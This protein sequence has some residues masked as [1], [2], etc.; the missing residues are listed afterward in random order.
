MTRTSAG[1]GRTLGSVLAAATALVGCTAGPTQAATPPA[2]TPVTDATTASTE[3][4][5]TS[6]G[7]AFRALEK[8]FD[9]D[10][11]VYALD[12]GTG[13]SVAF[14]ADRRFAY[15][16]TFKALQAGVLLRQRTDAQLEK[17]V[18]YQESDLL[19]YAPIT[20]EHLETGMTLRELADAS[21]RYSDNTAAN[22]LFEE[23]GGP[24]KVD[25]ALE[26]IGDRTTHVD[27]IE[28]D[29]NEATP[30]DIRDT[31][32]PRALANDLQKFVLGDALDEGDQAALTDLLRRNTT[33][34]KL[35]RA[36]VPQGWRVGDKTGAGRYGTR[37][38]IAVA[39]PTDGDPIVLAVL[40]TRDDQDA[41]YDDALIAR[42]TEVVIEQLG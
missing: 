27:R 9:A 24:A 7:K 22:L 16:S 41:T 31:S 23:L 1:R 39:W 35:I 25:K 4:S 28:P 30:G 3:A 17:V 29:L 10:L 38:D 14:R 33:G 15:A 5:T 32:T 37:N 40:S 6:S 18:R 20:R 21:V 8:A 11:G 26:R 2:T 13:R 42:A 36:G 19:D 34:D 12:T